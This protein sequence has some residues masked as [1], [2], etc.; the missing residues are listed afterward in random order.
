MEKGNESSKLNETE[1][2]KEKP[3]LNEKSAFSPNAIKRFLKNKTAPIKRAF[4]F[5][6][7]AIKSKILPKKAPKL[8][9]GDEFIDKEYTRAKSEIIK[10]YNDSKED[11]NPKRYFIRNASNVISTFNINCYEQCYSSKKGTI[12]E[13]LLP[14]QKAPLKSNY[15]E[16]SEIL[17]KYAKR[18]E[19][20]ILVKNETSI[21]P[22][23]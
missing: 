1:K 19:K 7:L 12:S 14:L 21:K 18:L 6:K 22:T 23:K 17:E 20:L 15:E 2:N 8:N 11:A 13:K 4:R 10:I 3:N 16:K 5:T 9:E